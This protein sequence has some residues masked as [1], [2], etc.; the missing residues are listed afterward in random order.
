SCVPVGR[1]VAA[2]DRAATRAHAQV[3]PVVAGLQ[4][5]LAA[6]DR[7]RQRGGGDLIEVCAGGGRRI[8]PNPRMNFASSDI[9]SGVHGGSKVSSI[10]TSSTPSTWRIAESM[11]DAMSGPAGQPIEV[12]L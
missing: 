9:L 1:R 2:A 3:H 8:Y 7:R 12:R 5:L 10:S 6:G 4:A 11:S